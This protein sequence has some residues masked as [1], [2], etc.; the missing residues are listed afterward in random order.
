MSKNY[1]V[2]L[3]AIVFVYIEG[4]QTYCYKNC[5]YK[6]LNSTQ[7]GKENQRT[8]NKN[9]KNVTFSWKVDSNIYI[10]IQRVKHT[11]AKP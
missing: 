10:K 5:C 9:P 8:T 7:V 11:K 2:I 1:K 6:D 3:R 4:L